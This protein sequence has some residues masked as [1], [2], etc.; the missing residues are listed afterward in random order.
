MARL[1]NSTRQS[2]THVPVRICL[3]CHRRTNRSAICGQCIVSEA[4]QAREESRAVL[5]AREMMEIE[6]ARNIR[7]KYAADLGREI[8]NEELSPMGKMS[9]ADMS[10]RG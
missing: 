7:E 3:K 5:T 1:G 6:Y 4:R 2:G 8:D 9:C 10:R